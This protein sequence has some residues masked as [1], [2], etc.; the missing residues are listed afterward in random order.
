MNFHERLKQSIETIRDCP[1]EK[2]D[3]T[4][5]A[6]RIVCLLAEI[7]FSKDESLKSRLYAKIKE[8]EIEIHLHID[9]NYDEQIMSIEYYLLGPFQSRHW[10]LTLLDR[11][12]K[13]VSRRSWNI[14]SWWSLYRFSDDELVERIGHVLQ[15]QFFVDTIVEDYLSKVKRFEA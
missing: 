4:K 2:S 6:D 15:D 8:K 13:V 5:M 12:W 14:F 10:T 7:E 11:E 1:L 9:D 3:I